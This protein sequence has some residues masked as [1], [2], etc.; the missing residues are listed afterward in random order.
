MLLK[1]LRKK[2]GLA[3]AVLGMSVLLAACGGKSGANTAPA[4]NANASKD[5]ETT[6]S[7]ETETAETATSSEETDAAPEAED[8]GTV[9]LSWLLDKGP[10]M[11]SYETYEESPAVKYWE[12]RDWVTAD[13][14]M[15]GRVDISFIAPPAGS[16]QE[17]FNTL[18]ATAEYPEVVAMM[19]S[20][21]NAQSLY[22]Q[23]IAIDLTEYVEKYMPNY[24]KW[25]D[26]H[27]EFAPG[28]KNDGKIIMLYQTA[29]GPEQA[30]GGFVYRRDWIL[31]YGKNPET[32]EAFT[33]G[34]NADKTEW[35]DDIVFPSGNEDP[36]YI[37]DWEWMFEIFAEALKGEGITDGYCVQ[38]YYTGY[39]TLG[40]INS[41]FGGNLGYYVDENGKVVYGGTEDGIR[42][43]LTCMNHW[44]EEG[45]MDPR[46]EEHTSDIIWFQID[47][48]NVFSGKVGLW[49]GLGGQVGDKMMSADSPLLSDIYVSSCP[50]PINDVYGD[51]SCQNQ[52]PTVFY[53]GDLVSTGVVVT[54]KMDEE[55]LPVLL[56]AVDYLYSHEGSL[57][58][59]WGLS[60]EQ[61]HEVQ[62]PYYNEL[63]LQDGLYSVSTDE[64][65]TETYTINEAAHDNN[66][67]D[68]IMA[69]N[70]KRVIGMSANANVVQTTDP[71]M[72]HFYEQQAKYTASGNV[73][74]MISGKL[75]AEESTEGSLI[76]T[77]V[78]TYLSQAVPDFITGRT[79]I[80]DDAAWQE[81][82]DT[83]EGYGV[84]S[85]VDA[86]NAAVGE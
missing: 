67:L 47:S 37:S 57:L 19:Y 27:P 29:D 53:Q 50:A 65:G 9:E 72:L 7:A 48:A 74:S 66:N 30:W 13:G 11:D 73:S 35:T 55:K 76:N 68:V 71:D 2:A 33:G 1:D 24:T 86:L 64:D 26:E 49:Y 79:D 43:F 39:Y 81:Y 3:A 23:G 62:D 25:M 17:N 34:W 84:Q 52:E 8:L 70:M 54:N 59:S 16:E 12:D 36:V 69:C 14:E 18:L 56:T 80:N 75:S 6:A 83:V 38:N 20:S 4:D 51:A 21:E 44:Y 40:E 41:S 78:L 45:W 32:G 58:R 15:K 22:D 61:Q 10:E 5:T 82:C 31:K 63:G 46:F 28:M 60:E 42:A 77:N 85:L